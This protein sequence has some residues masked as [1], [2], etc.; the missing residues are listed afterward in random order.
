[1]SEHENQPI[2]FKDYVEQGQHQP[3]KQL[4]SA[5]TLQQD[6]DRL[7]NAAKEA[8]IDV[9]ELADRMRQKYGLKGSMEGKY[10]QVVAFGTQHKRTFNWNDCTF[11]MSAEHAQA[12]AGSR[13][14]EKGRADV[15]LPAG[16]W[17]AGDSQKD[18]VAAADLE[19]T[20]Q[21]MEAMK[22]IMERQVQTI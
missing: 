17:T 15:V 13:S 16:S 6:T 9:V 14:L 7:V 10:E 19:R 22:I 18:N 21:G 8:N 2:T 20:R 11:Y 3:A 1:M 5:A 4:P 12:L